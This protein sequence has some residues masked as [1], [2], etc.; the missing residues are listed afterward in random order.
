[1]ELLDGTP[2]S[3]NTYFGGDLPEYVVHWL[4]K[5]E[6]NRTLLIGAINAVAKGLCM[7]GKN[8]KIHWQAD[9]WTRNDGGLVFGRWDIAAK[10][11][12]QAE[13]GRHIG[14]ISFPNTS[15]LQ[16]L[17][18]FTNL[19]PAGLRFEAPEAN[20]NFDLASI[21]RRLHATRPVPLVEGGEIYLVPKEHDIYVKLL[22]TNFTPIPILDNNRSFKSWRVE[23]KTPGDCQRLET[24]LR[25]LIVVYRTPANLGFQYAQG[26]SPARYIKLGLVNPADD[27]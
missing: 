24:A 9:H 16:V 19:V 18:S 14:A 13:V 6:E 27:D 15:A 1:M 17:I 5:S 11:T 25:D 20:V 10:S 23:L 22:E 2:E 8:G 12:E 3:L 26:N 21:T 4:G 7:I